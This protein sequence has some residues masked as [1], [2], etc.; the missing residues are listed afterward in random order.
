M[1]RR[2][3]TEEYSRADVRRQF[4]LSE[5]QLRSWERR[6]LI[7]DAQTYSF[8]DLIA[9][10]TVVKLRENR[11]R[12]P[13]IGEAIESLRQVIEEAAL[14][15]DEARELVAEPLGVVAGVGVRA[16]GV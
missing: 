7:P 1:A 15:F 2:A 13:R 10:Q 14:G 8:S 16:L 12:A 11:I 4:K 9:I 5:R 6:G 3:P